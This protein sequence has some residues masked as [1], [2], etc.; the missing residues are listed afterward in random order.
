MIEPGRELLPVRRE[1]GGIFFRLMGLLALAL[2]V[3]VV[4]LVRRPLLRE[5]GGFWVVE[6]PPSAADSLI[7]LSD[8]DYSAS[9]AGKAAELYKEH[10]APVVV[11]SGRML[12]P[13][14]GIG[15]LMQRDLTERGV[16]AGA[17]VIAPHRAGDTLD[18]AQ[19]L[20]SLVVERKWRHV[21]IVT[22]NYH[23]RR[24]RYIFRK[25]FPAGVQVDVS[26]AEDPSFPA[27]GWWDKKEGWKIFL[28]ETAG[29]IEAMWALRHEPKVEGKQTGAG[30]VREGFRGAIAKNG[31]TVLKLDFFIIYIL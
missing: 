6:D 10:R 21:I 29:M 9:R 23:T 15:E 30:G 5:A 11:A 1:R 14:A 2:L 4:Y 3:F 12:R 28:H 25:V 24:A 19:A 7:I 18:E 17:I 22:S 8:D 26:P 13:Y 31:T 16:P 20:R 27:N